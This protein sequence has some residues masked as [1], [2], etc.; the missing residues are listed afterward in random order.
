MASSSSSRSH[1]S[2]SDSAAAFIE[3]VLREGGAF[4]VRSGDGAALQGSDAP[5][6][7]TGTASASAAPQQQL[8]SVAARRSGCALAGCVGAQYDAFHAVGLQYGPSYRL[9]QQAWACE[10][11]RGDGV[12]RGSCGAAAAAARLAGGG[13][14]PGRPGW[15]DTARCDAA[16]VEARTLARCCCHSRWIALCLRVVQPSSGRCAAHALTP[17]RA[18]SM[19]AALLHASRLCLTPV[20]CHA[21]GRGAAGR[22][23]ARAAG[24]CR[25][26][27]GAHPRRLQVQG[28]ASRRCGAAGASPVLNCVGAAGWQAAGLHAIEVLLIGSAVDVPSP[29]K[30]G[31]INTARM[32]Q[33][34]ALVMAPRN[35]LGRSAL[36]VAE[37]VLLLL[38]AV[39]QV[40]AAPVAW[41]LTVRA[42]P[43]LDCTMKADPADAG[44]WGLGR[45]SRMEA[46]LS[47][48]GCID[49]GS[50]QA[51]EWQ[52][53]VWCR[54][55]VHVVSGTAAELEHSCATAHTHVP[56]LAVAPPP[57]P[58]SLRLHLHARGAISNLVVEPLPAFIESGELPASEARLRVH[59]VS[60]NFRDVLNVLGE[61]PGDPGP[62]GGDCSGTVAATGDGV[63]HL[64]TGYL[65]FGLAHAPLASA[66][67]SHALLLSCMEQSLSF[68]QACTLPVVWST[69]HVALSQSRL[70]AAQRLLV[71]AAVGGMGIAGIEAARWLHAAV[72]ASAS[73]PYKH[74]Q[75]R[76]GLGVGSSCS[77]R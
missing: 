3:C 66:A 56:R 27:C 65:A 17:A 11:R 33:P 76:R 72:D 28:A 8:G 40:V 59:A 26:R 29:Q 22:I 1:D 21:G 48:I 18:H 39:V 15:C 6:H 44:P 16:A 73:R 23:G 74:V 9:L 75:L 32:P 38:S 54:M 55:L 42:Q 51:C 45:S 60:L 58:S 14:A 77:S 67:L 71:H 69:V 24:G 50:A 49:V 35:M 25:W 64:C 53:A 62:P 31:T 61:Y 36:L 68:E 5:T 7:C 52:P 47:R 2:G 70:C 12:W 46:P 34:A 57:S 37:A 63:A 19:L 10:Q 30:K 4:E 13:G 20:H 41:L 43:I